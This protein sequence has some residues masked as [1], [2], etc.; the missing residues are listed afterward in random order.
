MILWNK[1]NATVLIEQVGEEY[2]TNA[3]V[4]EIKKLVKTQE[5]TFEVHTEDG[6]GK[7]GDFSIA[8]DEI[9]FSIAIGDSFKKVSIDYNG[10]EV[11]D[12][13]GGGGSITVDSSLSSTSENPVQN[14]AI[15]SA[16]NDINTALSGVDTLIGSGV[17]E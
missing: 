8:D 10:V 9:I 12:A 17:I 3:T 11:T 1:Q 15:Y 4:D 6:F 7:T 5:V 16:I 2:K 13:S 14:K